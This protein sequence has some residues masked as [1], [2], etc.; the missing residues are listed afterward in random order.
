VKKLSL[1]LN[2]VLLV[3]VGFLYYLHFSKDEIKPILN[4]VKGGV[5][6]VYVNADSLFENYDYYKGAKVQMEAKR[7]AIQSKFEEKA[8]AL[9]VEFTQYQQKAASL[10]AD[11][12]QKV[13]QMLGQKQQEFMKSR[14]AVSQDI[15]DEEAKI[16]SELYDKIGDYLSTQS[17]YGYEIVFGYAKGGGILYANP[18]LNITA[19]ILKGLNEAF[20]KEPKPEVET[21]K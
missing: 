18:G 12:R 4:P 13:E 14:E 1:I 5:K 9:E 10:T 16:H 6:L 20:E 7:K 21:K 17:K 11:Q 2:L 19:P 15:E 3:A 8:K